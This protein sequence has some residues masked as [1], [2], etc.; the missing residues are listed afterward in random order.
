MSLQCCI[1]D[2]TYFCKRYKTREFESLAS[3]RCNKKQQREFRLFETEVDHFKRPCLTFLFC[4][5]IGEWFKCG[6]NSLEWDYFFP[7]SHLLVLNERDFH[8][9]TSAYHLWRISLNNV[10][11]TALHKSQRTLKTSELNRRQSVELV[12]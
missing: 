3:L 10:F 7:L 6:A 4:W 11:V 9:P 2:F 12:L 8:H 1:L 5:I